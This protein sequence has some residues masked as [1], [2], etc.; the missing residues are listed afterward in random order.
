MRSARRSPR[1]RSCRPTRATTDV[2]ELVWEQMSTCYDPEI[3][4][5]IVDLGLVYE[6][7]GDA[8]S[9]TARVVCDQDDADRARLRHGRSAGAGRARKV[10]IIPT[11]K[12]ADVELVFDPPWNQTHDVRG[13]APADRHDV[14][15]GRPTTCADSC[16]GSRSPRRHPSRPATTRSVEVDGRFVA[17]FNIDGEFFAIDDLCTHDGGGLAGGEVEG[18]VVICPRHG[19]RFCL[20]TGEALTPPAYEPVRT[21]RDARHRRHGRGA[22]PT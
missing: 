4:I 11:V 19:A 6:C 12:R 3:P 13:G 16:R 21:Y 8:P 2:R 20:R 7:D 9:R 1:R 14:T 17:V 22:A 18:D 10:E 5:N 15:D